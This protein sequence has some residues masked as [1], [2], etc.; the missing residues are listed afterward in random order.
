MGYPPTGYPPMGH[1]PPV[2]PRR[3]ISRRWLI[4]GGIAVGFLSLLLVFV[5]VIYGRIGAY[6]IRSKVVPKLEAKLGRT[7]EIGDVEV[8][9]GLAVLENVVIKGPKDKGEP[10]CRI[11]PVR[12]DTYFAQ[13]MSPAT[14]D[15]F[16]ARGQQWLAT[17]GKFEHEGAV[18]D[19]TRTYVRQQVRSKFVVLE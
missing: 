14:F 11:M 3:R 18:A 7:V 1:Y 10:L 15:D 16:F 13:Q 2:F 4:I 5:F 6:M 9:R 8:H 19:I 17:H 12:R